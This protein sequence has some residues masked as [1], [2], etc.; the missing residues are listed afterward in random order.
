MMLKT[1][2]DI[3]S[4]KKRLNI[5]IPAEAIE[6]EIKNSLDYLR[7]K[8]KIPGFRPG[9]APMAIIQKRFGKEVEAEAMDK[10]IPRFY[11][12]ALKQA[13]ILPVS[14]PTIEGGIEYK[15]DNPL[16]FTVTVEIRP[17]IEGLNY[18]GIKVKDIPVEVGDP[19]LE[20][21]LGRLREDKASFEPT[22][23]PVGDGDLVVIDYEIKDDGRSFKDQTFRVG[24]ELMPGA[25]SEKLIGMP[26]AGEAEFEVAFPEGFGDSSLAGRT[27]PFKVA[28]KE[29]KKVVLPDMDD[30]FARDLEFDDLDAL[31][32]HVRERLEKS[33]KE[34]VA[35]IMKAEVLKK[36][37]AAQDFDVPES[38]LEQ[39]LGARVAEARAGGRQE[40]E[41]ALRED[42][43]PVA[44]RHIKAT[45]LL[46]MIGEK[47]NVEVTEEDMKHRIASVSVQ[48]GLTPE[49]IVKYYVSRD[50]S[51][52]GMRQS[53]YE[54][55]VLGLLLERAEI[56]SED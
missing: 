29:I 45:F 17:K 8:T 30:E 12:E 20:A 42:L 36:I 10:V 28:V 34:A 55:K 49:N 53:V 48:S 13:D 32:K 23:G 15:K 46:Q 33:R 56:V 54:D 52:E 7:K 19:D 43:R 11:S 39:E 4:T 26:K 22:E 51:L 21:A 2:E 31:R 18:E 38:L 41:A 24:S 40:E 44:E 5:E 35:N 1:I 25:F 3:S 27:V 37:I 16:S 47:E 9:K 6:G 50:G 14:Q